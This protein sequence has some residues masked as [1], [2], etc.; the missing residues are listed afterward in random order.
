MAAPIGNVVIP[1]DIFSFTQLKSTDDAKKILLGPGLKENDLE[2]KVIRPGI[3]RYRKPGVYWVDCHHKRYI[4]SKGESVIGIVNQ[5][6]GDIFRVDIGGSEQASLSYLS[7][8][9]ATKRNRP[10]VKVGDIIYAKLL[11]ANKDMEP[12]IVCIDSYGRSSGMGVIRNGGFLFHT[13]LNLA[14]KLLNPQCILLKTLGNRFQFEITVGINGR[15]WVKAHSDIQTIAIVNAIV[16]SEYKD[17]D[18]IKEMCKR[19]SKAVSRME[20]D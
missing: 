9:G 14:R 13:S 10:D 16:A 5:K 3:L 1:G 7:F 18:Q 4:P 19:I 17:N 15:V 20:V 11:V 2:I 12:E 6:V 8:E